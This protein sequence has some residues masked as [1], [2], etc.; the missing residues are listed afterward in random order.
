MGRFWQKMVELVELVGAG[1]QL[2]FVGVH[3]FG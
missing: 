3:L 2:V 1:T